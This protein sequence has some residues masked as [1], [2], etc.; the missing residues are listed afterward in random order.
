MDRWEAFLV[1]IDVDGNE[2]PFSPYESP[3]GH[4][5]RAKSASG[6]V[7]QAY[8]DEVEA[9]AACVEAG[10]RLCTNIEWTRAC[11]GADDNV[12]PYGDTREPGVCND[13]RDVHP[14]I[15]YFGTDADWIWSQLGNQCIDQQ[16]DTV[17]LTGAHAQCVDESGKF[18][19]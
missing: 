11:R 19:D 16:A 18:F 7:P 8:L 10:K 14:A 13:H 6:A 17:A 4:T 15:E 5:V 12:Y 9:S 3:S 1:E 2:S